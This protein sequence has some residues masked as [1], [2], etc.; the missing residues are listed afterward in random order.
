MAIAVGHGVWFQQQPGH[1]GPG[2]AHEQFRHRQAQ[3]GAFGTGGPMMATTVMCTM[4]SAFAV[5]SAPC[6]PMCR[7]CRCR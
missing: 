2:G 3:S 1:E 5:P 4:F 6:A 7:C